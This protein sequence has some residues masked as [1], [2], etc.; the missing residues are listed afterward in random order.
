V[1]TA[2]SSITENL[3]DTVDLVRSLPSD[4]KPLIVADTTEE[5]PAISETADLLDALR[6]KRNERESV[7]Q[8][9]AHPNTEGLRI[10]ELVPQQDYPIE[11]AIVEDVEPEPE[12]T[13]APV[14][15][16]QASSSKRGRASIPSWDQIVFGTKTED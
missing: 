13:P 2:A 4:S 1:A 14:A 10:V 12:P 7:E 3:G 11:E 9:D 5:E 16:D 8:L 6:R 15:T